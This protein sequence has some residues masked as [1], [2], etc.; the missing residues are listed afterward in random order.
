MSSIKVLFLC[1]HNSA[2]SQ[3][4]EAYLKKLGGDKFLPESAGLEPGKLN[5]LVVEAMKQEGIDISKNK[6]KDVF[7][8][9]R[10]GKSFDYVITVCDPKSSEMCPIFPGIQKKINWGFDDPS[11]FAGSKE[12]KIAQT[13]IIRDKI[14]KAVQDFILETE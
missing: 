5:P 4:A 12:E 14:K 10:Q 2:R 1:I 8:M 6:T 7:E 9:H 13:K 11:K 3:M